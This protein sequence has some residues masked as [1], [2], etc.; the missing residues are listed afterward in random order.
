M[1]YFDNAAT[2]LM[3]PPS[4]AE[5]VVRGIG[6]FGG[7][8]RGVH[9]ASIASSLAVYEARAALARL[10]GTQG[11]GRVAFGYNATDA[12]NAA[13]EG[14]LAPGAHA[15]TT[16]ASHN[17]VLRPLYRKVDREGAELSIAPIAPDGS[18]DLEAYERL[19]RPETSL[20]V[21]THASNV[22]GD[23]YD[24]RR[25]AR[26]ARD[27]GAL[28]V[29]DAAQTAGA[30]PVDVQGDGFDAVVFTGHKSL[31]G[32]QGTGGIA[33]SSELEVPPYRVG[34]SGTHSYDRC[35]PSF[36]PERLE[37]GTLNAHG[38]AGLAAGVA[39]IEQTGLAAIGERVQS[40]ARRF[41]EAV[42]QIEGVRIYGGPLDVPRCG[43]VALNVGRADSALVADRLNVDFGICT[44][45]GA[46]CAP[47]M[48]EALGTSDRGAVRFSFSHFNTEEEIDK[49]VEALEE[50]A[51]GLV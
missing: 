16:A 26:I 12:L 13:I 11:A 15:I 30:L 36:M 25:M 20:V 1:I 42:R 10:L 39:Y 44:R 21:A 17:S 50:I 37:A 41:G 9:E 35:H 4:V 7:P 46:H 43:I 29:L 19:F 14:L 22:T 3:K 48:H 33:L 24:V 31:F 2:T 47:F 49:G 45:A 8:A 40:L 5:A 18:L 27:H 38:L 6:S 23:V 34:G 32:P 51:R 28:F